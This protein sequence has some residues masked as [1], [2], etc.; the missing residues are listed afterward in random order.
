MGPVPFLGPLFEVV[1]AVVNPLLVLE[2]T[3][4]V[5]FSSLTVIKASAGEVSEDQG[6]D[7]EAE[8][9]IDFDFWQF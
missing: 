2:M 9:V 5:T 1:C 3:A 7:D 4:Q 8:V 6:V